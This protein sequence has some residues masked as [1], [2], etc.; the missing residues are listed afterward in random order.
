VSID[1]I[2]R[3]F[4]NH[5]ADSEE[6]SD[7]ENGDNWGNRHGATGAAGGFRTFGGGGAKIEEA[8][9]MDVESEDSMQV[10]LVEPSPEQKQ[11]PLADE[12]GHLRYVKRTDEEEQKPLPAAALQGEAPPSP[13][14]DKPPAKVNLPAGLPDG[15]S[16]AAPS[17]PGT[18]TDAAPAVD[19]VESATAGLGTGSEDPLVANKVS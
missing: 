19:G 8:D 15:T 12:T 14:K 17:L 1:H 6:E 9:D 10:D 5:D 16:K 3:L 2:R 18:G 11:K 4:G 7:E 13:G